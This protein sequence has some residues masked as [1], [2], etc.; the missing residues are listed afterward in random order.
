MK[1]DK[2]NKR[3]RIF[4]LGGI[5]LLSAAVIS[6]FVLFCVCLAQIH[7]ASDQRMFD[8]LG[9]RQ[10]T[11]I[12]VN[13]NADTEAYSPLEYDVVFGSE[14]TV[15]AK[16]DEIPAALKSAFIS[17]EDHRFYEHKGID[18]LRTGKAALN[19]MFHFDK[20]FGGS[21]ITQQLVK[22]VLNEKDISVKRKLKEAIRAYKIEKQYSKDEILTMY[23]NIVPLSNNCI[24]VA[25]ASQLYFG[26]K[27]SELSVAEC[28]SIACITNLPSAYDPIKKPQEHLK[29]RNLVLKQML[30]YGHIAEEEY[31]DAIHSPLILSEKAYEAKNSCHNWFVEYVLKDVTKALCE[32]LNITKEAATRLIYN[33]GLQIYTTMNVE[34]QEAVESFFKNK[35]RFMSFKDENIDFS[36][37]LISPKNGHLLALCGGLGEKQG[38]R[39]YCGAT[40]LMRPPGSALKPIA[41]YAPALEKGL[42]HY[43]TSFNDLPEVTENGEN[44]RMWPRNSPNVYQGKITLHEAIAKSK[45]TV[46]VQTYEMLGSDLVA[47]SLNQ[48]G[49][50][51]LREKMKENGKIIT[52]LAPSPLALGQLSEGVTLLALTQAYTGLA[53]EGEYRNCISFISV[54]DKDG[55]PL[56]LKESTPKRVYSQQNAY[57]MTQMLSE[58]VKYGTARTLFLKDRI[59]IAGKT[60]T[61]GGDLDRY[62]IGYTPNLLAGI[63]VSSF[64]TNPIGNRANSHIELWGEIIENI[65]HL[66]LAKK[67]QRSFYVPTGIEIRPFCKDSGNAP[68]DACNFDGRGN[69]IDYGPFTAANCPQSTCVLHKLVYYNPMEHSIEE[70]N[71]SFGFLLRPIALLDEKKPPYINEIKPLDQSYYLWYYKSEDIES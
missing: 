69:R 3:R 29:R 70:K 14:N 37:V 11:R 17:I 64:D 57:I 34:A 53:N 48:L 62:F 38:D 41:L 31:K 60:G 9:E 40:D 18:F 49:I 42:V 33:G 43:A 35:D 65:L 54:F 20:H 19:Y 71:E 52:D 24:G 5:A 66:D 45:N 47:Y 56:L 22:N 4:L 39:L 16:S 1:K 28:A 50:P 59:D 25:A 46:A 8:S 44:L 2:K 13:Q 7:S 12:Y 21:T 61:S 26:K 30:S 68:S 63:R 32:K 55:Q 58:V 6:I 67:F 36:F 23:L 51:L 15:L 27:L 10:S